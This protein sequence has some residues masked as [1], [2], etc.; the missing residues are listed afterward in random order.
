M[1]ESPALRAD[2]YELTM[3]QG[4][5][6]HGRSEEWAAFELFFRRIPEQ[7]GYCIAAGI[8]DA[9]ELVAQSRF[10]REQL[11]YLRTLDVFQPAFL[12][13]L[14]TLRFTGQVR[15]VSEGTV[16][17]PNEPILEIC[18]PIIEAQWL[19]SMLLNC[20]NFQTLIATK[21]SRIVQAA[22]PAD[23]IEFGLRRAHGPNGALWAS[24]A[25]YVGGAVGTSNLEAGARYRIPVFGT[26]AHSWVQSFDS[27]S[28]AFR[29]YSTTFPK[30]SVL[31]LDTYDTL[32][33][34]IVH[35]IAEGRRM[36]ALG[37]SLMGVRLDSGDLAYLSKECR[38]LLD[39]AGLPAVKI[40]ASS[41][42]DEYLLQDLKLQGAP[43]DAYGIG[44]RLVTAFSEPALGGVYKLVAVRKSGVWEPKIKISSNPAKT[45]IPGR[46][47]I[48]R[49][50][51]VDGF[52]ADALAIES[53]P[54]PHHMRHQDF[55][56]KQTDLPVDDLVP[57]LELRWDG[58]DRVGGKATLDESRQ[59]VCDQLA[60]LPA[61][62]KRLANP[63]T[64][65]VGVSDALYNLRREMIGT[66]G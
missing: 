28:D 19:E 42:I 45:T 10:H 55:E 13:Y 38:R 47:Q 30:S 61:E 56:Y 43:I 63:H 15:A 17:F 51:S 62:H 12:D 27:E 18:A 46:K 11:D 58:L 39:A 50:H 60:R 25:A 57:L 23:V 49:W 36:A 40:I 64:Y 37:Q 66:R 33:S 20:V 6:A 34:G 54:P 1:L 5:W 35:A 41:D 32:R 29:A 2:L 65:R 16:V 14:T 53:E 21:A 59:R 31:L 26:H 48:Y 7:G 8:E 52:Q 9:L 24:R 44:T 3:M 22:R 4:Y